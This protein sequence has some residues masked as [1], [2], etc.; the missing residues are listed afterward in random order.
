LIYWNSSKRNKHL[1]RLVNP[2]DLNLSFWHG[3]NAL[4]AT[5]RTLNASPAL[6]TQVN[7][8]K[9]AQAT[10]A[11]GIPAIARARSAGMQGSARVVYQIAVGKASTHEIVR[12]FFTGLPRLDHL[13][14]FSTGVVNGLNAVW[15]I[16][17]F[18]LPLV[19]ANR[20]VADCRRI[21]GAD[22]S[23]SFHWILRLHFEAADLNSVAGFTTRS[24]QPTIPLNR[25]VQSWTEN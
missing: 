24:H 22:R 7:P 17:E 8:G 14:P 4:Q 21:K 19:G 9:Y 25:A 11:T 16:N 18:R 1:V 23:I 6:I 12:F 5:A 2:E 15:S 3:T 20:L 10:L 13:T